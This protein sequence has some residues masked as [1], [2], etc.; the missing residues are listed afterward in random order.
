MS[1]HVK[2]QKEAIDIVSNIKYDFHKYQEY[3]N[4]LDSYNK[5]KDEQPPS[6][7]WYLANTYVGAFMREYKQSLF[8]M[9]RR[10]SPGPA[11]DPSGCTHLDG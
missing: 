8:E 9:N 4:L 11:L 5:S 3:D 7:G 1:S 2:W 10:D 6:L